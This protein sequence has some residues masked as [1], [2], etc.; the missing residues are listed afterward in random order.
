MEKWRRHHPWFTTAVT[1]H[2]K[3]QDHLITNSQHYHC[4]SFL[5][6]ADARRTYMMMVWRE[7]GWI[8]STPI[9]SNIGKHVYL[10]LMGVEPSSRLYL[11]LWCLR[12]TSKM[13]SIIVNW[14]NSTTRSPWEKERESDHPDGNERMKKNSFYV[15]KQHEHSAKCLLLC[16]T[17]ESYTGLEYDNVYCVLYWKPSLYLLL[18]LTVC[19]MV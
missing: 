10:S 14:L 18:E 2:N 12:N 4:N 15:K 13:S 17:E 6:S 9:L 7:E 8:L 3:H 16:S 1:R 11:C 5:S 19:S